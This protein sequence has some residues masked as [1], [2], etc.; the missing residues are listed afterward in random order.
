MERR[1]LAAIAA[2]KPDSISTSS[3]VGVLWPANPPRSAHK[4]VQTNVLRLRTLLGARTILTTEHGYRL[5]DHV[6]VDADRFERAFVD[7]RASSSWDPV[8]AMVGGIP[9]DDLSGWPPAEA[10]R[11]RVEELHRSALEYRLEALLDSGGA[12]ALVPELE[13]LVMTEPLRE[14]RWCLL[15]S[16]LRKAGRRAEALRAVAR[17]RSVLISELG[18]EPGRDLASLYESLLVDGDALV[19]EPH[20]G[21]ASRLSDRAYAEGES[22]RERGDQRAAV[23]A[24]CRAGHLARASGDARRLVQ[25]ALGAAGD[26]FTTGLDATDDVVS[27]LLD[28]ATVVPTAPTP[29]RSKL[30]S[31]LAITQ[32]YHRSQDA[33][34]R[35][36]QAAL[37]IAHT[38]DEPELEARALHALVVVVDDPMR[39]AER[40]AWLGALMRLADGHPDQPWRRWALPLAASLAALEGDVARAASLLDELAQLAVI[41]CDR[42]AT[43]AA[44]HRGLLAASIAGDWPE[45]RRAIAEVQAAGENAHFDPTAARLEAFALS[46]MIDLFEGMPPGFTPPAIEWPQPSMG[47]AVRAWHA[48]GL[49]RS[50]ASE[51]AAKALTEIAPADLFDLERDAYWL[52]TMGLLADATYRADNAAIGEALVEVVQGVLSLTI[53]DAGGLYRGSVAHAAGLASAACGRRSHAASL[54]AEAAALHDRQGSRWM[55]AE[56]RAA[57]E[58]LSS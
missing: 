13:E 1:V 3:L 39:L 22:A 40:V 34:E 5:A 28:A 35:D 12:E 4:V 15:V 32:S 27:L 37:A 7:A 55:A 30:L 36:A 54:L 20:R 52:P 46:G 48:D 8:L 29:T 53:V 51:A 26:G 25:A 49:A 6:D 50:G 58:V 14:K 10:R 57:L 18:I 2:S 47:F 56:S 45:A 31:R 11:A 19:E 43:Y 16:A 42:V 24:Y 17:A 41:S 9:F 44:A 23:L 21:D 38:L 33:G